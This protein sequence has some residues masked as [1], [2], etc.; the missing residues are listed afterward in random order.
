MTMNENNNK[1]NN[2]DDN[3]NN[4]DNHNDNHNDNVNVINVKNGQKNMH[5]K[6]RVL[7]SDQK[8]KIHFYHLG[9]RG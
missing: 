2:D 1:S 6:T 3:H 5:S 9:Y 7:G 8:L 4:N